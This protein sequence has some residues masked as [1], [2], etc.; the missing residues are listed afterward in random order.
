MSTFA[1]VVILLLTI[2]L[3]LAVGIGAGYAIITSILSAFAHTP[4]PKPAAVLVE[5]E[6]IGD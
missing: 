4:Q 6:T 3:S 5:Q 1:S 2:V